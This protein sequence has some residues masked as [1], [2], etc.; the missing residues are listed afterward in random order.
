MTFSLLKL[1]YIF[2]DFSESYDK[3]YLLKYFKKIKFIELKYCT[4][5]LR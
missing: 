3:I 5:K 1:F 4:S 2:I